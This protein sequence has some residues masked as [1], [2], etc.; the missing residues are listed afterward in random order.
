MIRTHPTADVSPQAKIGD[1]TNIW[2]QAQIRENAFIGKNCNIGKDV[3]IDFDVQI[4]NN[5]KIQNGVSIYHGVVIEDNV[6]MGPHCITTNDMFPRS[7]ISEFAVHKTLIKKGASVGAGAILV[8]GITVGEYAMIGAGAVVTKDV[9]AYSLV[10]GNPARTIGFVCK[11]GQRV[12]EGVKE[13]NSVLF[14][15][16]K[17][18]EKTAVP[19]ETYEKVQ[20]KK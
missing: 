18:G 19:Y 16:A 6:F 5:V 1:G 3:Y 9:P 14:K 11:C 8:C 15:C 20:S 2:N 10:V 7:W 12:S 13:G 4:G 17:C